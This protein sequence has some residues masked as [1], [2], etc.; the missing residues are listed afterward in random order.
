MKKN[1]LSVLLAFIIL[2]SYT[3]EATVNWFTIQ[4]AEKLSV[5]EPRPIFIDTYTDWCGWC[6]KMDQDTFSHPVIAEILNTKY[7][8][9]KFNAEG[10]ETI[11]FFGQT[12]TN[13]GKSGRAHQ[14]AIA[15]LNGRLSYPTVVFM[16][17]QGNKYNV[18]P[19]LAT[20]SPGIWKS[21]FSTSRRKPM[22]PVNG[23]TTR[24]TLW[25]K[26]SNKR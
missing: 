15:L 6:K 2:N 5:T 1:I 14:L 20:G 22:K 9:V 21:C 23:K 24:Q 25:E 19:C 3:Q 13:D 10:K 16:T 8:P 11:T 17:R 7:Y 4:E 18:S 26:S 12:F